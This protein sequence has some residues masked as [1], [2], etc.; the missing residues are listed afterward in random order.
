MSGPVAGLEEIQQK[1]RA[2]RPWFDAAPRKLAALENIVAAFPEQG[3][4]WARSLRVEPAVKPTG[5]TAKAAAAGAPALSEEAVSVTLAGLARSNDATLALRNALTKA[6]GV[7]NL[8][9]PQLRGN[10]PVQFS[11]TFQWQPAP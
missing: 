6:P 3:D 1:S 4:I 11:F 9:G 8:Q 2:L 5:A 7:R 10:N